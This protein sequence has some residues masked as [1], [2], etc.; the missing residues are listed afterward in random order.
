MTDVP[1]FDADTVRRVLRMD[2][3]I[4]LMAD[5]QAA[6]SR[7]E[8]APPLRSFVPVAGGK[9]GMGIMPGD[10]PFAFGAKLMSLY[11]G[12][13]ARGMPMIQGCILLFDRESGAPAALIEGASVTG[14]RTAAASGAATRALARED[15]SVLALLGYGVQ[16]ETHLEAMR[17]VRP[18][19][20][21]RVWGPG[22]EKAERF[23]AAHAD[24]GLAVTVVETAREAVSGADIVCA[25]SAASEPVI[26]GRL[27]AAGC[28]VNLVGSH[29]PTT[30]EADGE[31]MGRARVFTEITDF[32]MKEAGD[33]LLAIEEGFIAEDD[34]AGEIGAV[35]DGA[36]E[37]R[38]GEDEITLYKSL[39]NV[40]QDLAA[41]HFIAESLGS[42][43]VSSSPRE[44]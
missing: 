19:R 18:V 21:V 24:D 34:L 26:E 39:G 44:A 32:A 1:W 37:G 13:P 31:T 8:I 30:R 20:E 36:I 16:A 43:D 29:T 42:E 40:A 35:I 6:I 17:C 28:H 4:D 11:S 15:A 22:L 10:A 2:A 27:L 23:A 5:T 3:C 12:N 7:G 33:I 14:I 38:R 9:G 25:V 41:A